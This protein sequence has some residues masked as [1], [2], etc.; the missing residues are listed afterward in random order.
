METGTLVNISLLLMF[1]IRAAND[2]LYLSMYRL[3][4]LAVQLQSVLVLKV[5]AWLSLR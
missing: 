5:Q 2:A 4:P 1:Q 3:N